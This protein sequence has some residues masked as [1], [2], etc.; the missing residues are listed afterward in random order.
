[1][2]GRRRENEKDRFPEVIEICSS[3]QSECSM[4]NEVSASHGPPSSPLVVVR[5]CETDVTKHF[6][7][8]MNLPQRVA[9]YEL[10][11]GDKLTEKET[12]TVGIFVVDPFIYTGCRRENED[13]RPAE[14]AGMAVIQGDLDWTDFFFS[15]D[16][17]PQPQFFHEHSVPFQNA[18]CAPWWA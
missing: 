4:P 14:D 9:P 16:T 7:A 15:L 2:M 6:P 13:G 1:M 18:G 5:P 11:S 3:E 17:M 8:E 10:A 12:E